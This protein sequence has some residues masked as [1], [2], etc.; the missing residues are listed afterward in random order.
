M[1]RPLRGRSEEDQPQ[2][3][4]DRRYEECV[5]QARA[6]AYRNDV[7]ITDRRNGNH[8]E[9]DDVS[10]TEV[11]VDIVPETVPIEPQQRKGKANQKARRG[12]ADC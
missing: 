9:I 1:R 2:E 4:S 5:D 8:C 11:T 7:A 10:E 12:D 6:L 3:N